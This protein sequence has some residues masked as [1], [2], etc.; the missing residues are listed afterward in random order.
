MHS[1]YAFSPRHLANVGAPLTISEPEDS[2]FAVHY[3]SFTGDYNVPATLELIHR[4]MARNMDMWRQ[5]WTAD[6]LLPGGDF[7]V[8]F[9][10][11]DN[12]TQW[13]P[14]NH[15]DMLTPQWAGLFN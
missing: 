11:W 3:R 4:R 7:D 5:F 9:D 2:T 8:A 10:E 13:A 6:D 15:K 12:G 14:I 1:Y